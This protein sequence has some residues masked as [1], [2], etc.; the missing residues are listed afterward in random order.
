METL[1]GL[2]EQVLQTNHD[3]CLRLGNLESLLSHRSMRS[4]TS[5]NE[6]DE[7][8]GASTI[9]SIQFTNDPVSEWSG[10]GIVD[11]MSFTFEQ[12]L[13]QSR[14]YK[15]AMQ[16]HSLASLSSSAAPSL[17][18]SCLSKMSLANVSNI[19]VISLPITPNELS[20]GEH[21]RQP[22]IPPQLSMQGI[23]RAALLDRTGLL[24][25]DMSTIGRASSGPG[26]KIVI[27]GEKAFHCMQYTFDAMS[28]LFY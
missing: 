11:G 14:V 18:W 22:P 24:D 12:D 27:L 26:K 15:R 9:R 19:S 7:E 3:I 21:Y 2:V 23:H 5:L 10:E 1:T 4:N 8:D 28:C 6:D 16:R 13:G 17:G 20:N 25:H